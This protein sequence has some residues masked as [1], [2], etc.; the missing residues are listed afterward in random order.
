MAEHVR[1]TRGYAEE[2]DDLFIR[3]ESYD[4]ESVHAG[5][6][7]FIPP[8]PGLV[9]DIGAG[10][11]RDAAWFSRAG[12]SVV[13]VE[14]SDEMRR[15]AK[16]LHPE[17]DIE[18]LDDSLPSLG[19]LAGREGTFDLVQLSAVWM[20]LD[21]GERTAALSRLARLMKPGGVLTLMVRHGPVPEGRIM[22]EVPTEEMLM[23]AEAEG[24][25]GLLCE[26]RDAAG[27]ANRKAGVT[28]MNYAF[29]KPAEQP[30]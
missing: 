12:Y 10:T 3:Y 2:A 30:G 6:L 9:L 14:P 28:W 24:L 7:D 11:G 27:E 19:L 17:P 18:W 8:P 15:R 22:F 16:A 4:F 13:A 5:W 23:L 29:R 20:H 26:K 25:D 1:G 21:A